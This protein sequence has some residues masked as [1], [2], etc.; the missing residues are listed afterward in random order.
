[1]LLPHLPGW[2][3]IKMHTRPKKLKDTKGL[4]VYP[5]GCRR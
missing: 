4:E 1:V 5:A 3:F 2:F